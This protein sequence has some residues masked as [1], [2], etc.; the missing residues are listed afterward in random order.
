MAQQEPV[1]VIGAGIGGLTTAAALARAGVDVTVLE[2]HVYPGGCAGAFFHKNYRFEAGATLA[3]GFYSGGPMD[4]VG[5]AVG[6]DRWPA[7]PS[8][9]AM[10]VHLPD[11]EAITRFGDERRWAEHERAFGNAA[12]AFWQW[13][14]ETADALWD[15]ALRAPAWPPQ[16]FKEGGALANEGIRWL[17]RD[18]PARL[19]PRLIADAFRP[20][21][22]H[23]KDAPK[24]LRLFVD[25]QLLISAQSTSADANALYGAAALDLPRRGVVHLEGGI[26]AIADTLV[27]AVRRHGGRVLFRQEVERIV[28]ENGRPIAV[29]TKRGQRFPART[30]VANLPPWNLARLVGDDKPAPLRAL[31][32]KPQSGWGAFILYVGFDA[33]LAPPD[34]ALHHQVL[35]REPLGEGNSVFLSLSPAWDSSRAPAGRRALT[36]STHTALEPWWRLF[37]YDPKHYERRREHYV[38]RILRAA[39]RVLPGLRTAADLVLAGTPVTF[40]RFTRRAWGWV[41]GF[42]QTSLFQAWGPRVQPNLWMV[43]DSIF[44]GQSTA[45]V[46]LGGLRVARAV[47]D[48]AGARASDPVRQ[49]SAA[50]TTAPEAM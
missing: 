2:A 24:A 42:P 31:P 39:E 28:F 9:P 1:V 30:V 38:D 17:L 35:E 4:I 14:E 12:Q 3:G 40:E 21:A 34:L 15:L 6:I 48:E 46:A 5:R 19:H 8:D 10:T 27:E 44:P 16:S 32:E 36:I 18:L 41:G 22:H 49:R 29:E 45:A 33:R 43:G 25:A 23:L 11:G 47:L 50:R 20:V 26:G 7:H 13:Q 37:R